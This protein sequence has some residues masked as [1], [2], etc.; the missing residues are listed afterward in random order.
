V[1]FRVRF[2][3][4]SEIGDCRVGK[5]HLEGRGLAADLYG[6]FRLREQMA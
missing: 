2:Q 4:R 1:H 5:P 3:S 6:N